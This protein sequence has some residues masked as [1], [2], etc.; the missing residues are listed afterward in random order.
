MI[1]GSCCV[2]S[3]S[4]RTRASYWWNGR[5]DI[6]TGKITEWCVITP[7]PSLSSLRTVS[8]V[9]LG[10][11]V[12]VEKMVEEI[13]EGLELWR[14]VC[15]LESFLAFWNLK[16]WLVFELES[17]LASKLLEFILVSSLLEFNL[18]S[19][20]LE[21]VLPSSL[22]DIPGS[23]LTSSLDFKTSSISCLLCGD[24]SRTMPEFVVEASMY[25][26]QVTLLVEIV[27][28]WAYLVLRVSV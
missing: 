3:A 25:Q 6:I 2:W 18:S 14:W 8:N 5:E 17:V 10:W 27:A 13:G 21:S 15:G 19:S 16:C 12:M 24:N 9:S 11:R 1:N 7:S 4:F 28:S 26:F 20:V 22:D 23:F